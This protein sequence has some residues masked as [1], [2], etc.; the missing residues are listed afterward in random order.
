MMEF[1][2]AAR[3]VENYM[4][5]LLKNPVLV[6]DDVIIHDVLEAA[7][8]ILPRFKL[9][10]VQDVQ[11]VLYDGFE[12]IGFTFNS[13]YNE[14]MAFVLDGKP[15]IMNTGTYSTIL[16]AYVNDVAGTQKA[17]QFGTLGASILNSTFGRSGTV[18]S[19]GE[20][21]QTD[22]VDKRALSYADHELLERWITRVNGLSDMVTS[23]AVFLK[24]THP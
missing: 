5:K 17:A 16:T 9:M 2:Q 8:V 3:R 23:L 22:K 18:R 6:H 24:I 13:F 14:T 7:A 11:N 15:R 21:H 4:D 1:V 10:C 12:Q 19:Y 20:V